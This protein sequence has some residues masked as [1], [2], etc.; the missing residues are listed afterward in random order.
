MENELSCDKDAPTWNAN[1]A[2]LT[3]PDMSDL[4]ESSSQ[5]KSPKKRGRRKRRSGE[6]KANVV[7]GCIDGDF[8]SKEIKSPR[9]IRQTGNSLAAILNEEPETVTEDKE[10]TEKCSEKRDI[11]DK[12]HNDDNDDDKRDN[13]MN[14][15][16]HYVMSDLKMEAKELPDDDVFTFTDEKLESLSE[17]SAKTEYVKKC[18]GTPKNCINDDVHKNEL[19]LKESLVK[20]SP[21]QKRLNMAKEEEAANV[22]CDGKVDNNHNAMETKPKPKS[23]KGK[24]KKANE[25]KTDVKKTQEEDVKSE[26]ATKHDEQNVNKADIDNIKVENTDT[27]PETVDNVDLKANKNK[28]RKS[29]K[30]KKKIS[31]SEKMECDQK[32]GCGDDDEAVSPSKKKRCAKNKKT[33]ESEKIDI[34]KS[35]EKFGSVTSAGPCTEKAIS[36]SP[37]SSVTSP[38]S[39]PDSV[40]V[41]PDKVSGG[42][43]VARV[44]PGKKRTKKL[45]GETSSS[46]SDDSK[47]EVSLTVSELTDGTKD[48][49]KTVKRKRRKRKSSEMSGKSTSES[50]LSSGTGNEEA[51]CSQSSERITKSSQ[52]GE[53]SFVEKHSP[54]ETPRGNG[55]NDSDDKNCELEMEVECIEEPDE[56]EETKNDDAHVTPSGR[57]KRKQTIMPNFVGLDEHWG[58]SDDDDDKDF[59]PKVKGGKKT[60]KRASIDG[61]K[62]VQN[63]RKS[64]GGSGKKVKK[65][66]PAKNK[67][68]K[69][70]DLEVKPEFEELSIKIS[71]ESSDCP[72]LE[73]VSSPNTP[74]P[75]TSRL[76]A[77]KTSPACSTNS[78]PRAKKRKTDNSSSSNKGKR[79]RGKK[80]PLGQGLLGVDSDNEMKVGRLDLQNAI[81]LAKSKNKAKKFNKKDENSYSGPIVRLK[82]GKENPTSVEIINTHD[83]ADAYRVSKR[84]GRHGNEI[85]S[86]R[87]ANTLTYPMSDTV[88]W[89]CAFC[90]KST[91]YSIL[92]DLFGPYFLENSSNNNSGA[93]LSPL[94]GPGGS[95]SEESEQVMNKRKG[96]PHS[97]RGLTSAAAG[98]GCSGRESK[99]RRWASKEAML[100]RLVELACNFMAWICMND[101]SDSDYKMVI[102]LRMLYIHA[103][104]HTVQRRT[105]L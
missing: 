36:K 86:E 93:L 53:K 17:L 95:S 3:P 20:V 79:K 27:K 24:V 60:P 18:H 39:P 22:L 7:N 88:P 52:S 97:K 4:G 14:E 15:S 66:P 55:R 54:S 67:Q 72:L 11:S 38:I 41:S 34:V 74:Q 31:E 25:H 68:S 29:P 57:R 61:G 62:G 65:T 100:H 48:V 99:R 30:K 45:S 12:K 104:I 70:G 32:N 1:S 50:S 37:S 96:K 28:V 58:D 91:N 87:N 46:V 64:T 6:D 92:G 90:G 69:V 77:V 51:S 13:D 76:L 16:V 83:A 103:L 75:S 73:K 94:N 102:Q 33:A 89:I 84:K 10:E 101:E 56:E 5:E 42:A 78:S 98:A 80:I 43:E 19:T 71:P 26:P 63:A 59:I 21:K 9:K 49:P 82:G 40:F 44:S 8:I 105:V 2:T 47:D 35:P 85:Q 81:K 23:P